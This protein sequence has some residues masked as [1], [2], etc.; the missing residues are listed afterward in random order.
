M[1]LQSN[2][3]LTKKDLLYFKKCINFFLK[4]VISLIFELEKKFRYDAILYK[5]DGIRSEGCSKVIFNTPKKLEGTEQNQWYES[6][7]LPKEH[8]DKPIRYSE[9]GTKENPVYDLFISDHF[10]VMAKFVLGLE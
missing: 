9:R 5:G 7:I 8:D 3:N 1:V 10:G 2:I 6:T 4:K